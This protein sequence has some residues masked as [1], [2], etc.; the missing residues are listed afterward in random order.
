MK[1]LFPELDIESNQWN[2]YFNGIY[3]SMTNLVQK[4]SLENMETEKAVPTL[5]EETP[6]EQEEFHWEVISA[7]AAAKP[8]EKNL[9]REKLKEKSN[10]TE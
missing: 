2:I 6:K 3:M 5:T 10:Y 7:L 1:Y 9:F 8:P 4:H